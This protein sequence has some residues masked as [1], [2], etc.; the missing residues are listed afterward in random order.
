M[1]VSLYTSRVV[2]QKLGVQDYGIYSVVGGV[3]AMFGFLNA[4]ISGATQ[5]FLNFELG[6]NDK[7]AVQKVFSMSLLIHGSIAIIII[8][9]AETLG[10]WFLQTKMNIPNERMDAAFW[11]YQLSILSCVIMIV[12]VPYNALIIAHERM[13]AF[14]YV[15]IVEVVLK[16]LVVYIIDLLI[17]DTLILYA[18]LLCAVQILIRVIYGIYC[19]CFFEES[20]FRLFWDKQLFKKMTGIAFWTMNGNL[21]FLGYTQGLNILL[22]LFFNPAVNA[23]RGISLQVQNAVMGLCRNFQTAMNPQIT[24]SYAINDLPYM[25]N[26]IITGSRF[27]FF[28]LFFI[29]LPILFETEFLLNF[30]LKTVPEHTTSFVR[31]ILII[32]MSEALSRPL[33]T[34]VYATGHLRT[35]QLIEGSI[36]LFIIP[37]SYLFLRLGFVPEIVFIV[38]LCIEMI[39]QCA[40]IA[41]VCPMI[42]LSKWIYCKQVLKQTAIVLILSPIIPIFIKWVLHSSTRW[43]WNFIAVSICCCVSTAFCSYLFGMNRN[44][45]I[46]VK[47]KLRLIFNHTLLVNLITKK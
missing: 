33:I 27:S 13:N 2:L 43:Q 31:L 5:R 32:S 35:F 41:I 26:L 16:L 34:A 23:A 15:S 8:L 9:L 21:A 18:L 36:S 29:S 37:V 45:K 42:Q 14:A 25:H 6:K 40:R 3:V 44:E 20:V 7:I 17:Y 24:K 46:M 12:S 30:W 10:L 4:S 1:G 11:V 28:L 47:N 38:H 39:T 22:N 19:K